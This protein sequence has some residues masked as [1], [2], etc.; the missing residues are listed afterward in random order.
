MSKS[1]KL[2]QSRKKVNAP[3]TLRAIAR[4][5]T[6]QIRPLAEDELNWFRFQ[7]D[8]GK[9]IKFAGLAINSKGKRYSHQRRIRKGVLPQAEYLLTS[10]LKAIRQCT[11]FG[12][13]FALINS[14]LNSVDGIGELYIYDT[15]LRIGANLNLL[16][17]KIYLHTGTREGA[18]ALGFGGKLAYIEVSDLPNGL[19]ELEPHEIEDVLCIFKDNLKQ[20]KFDLPNQEIRRRSWCD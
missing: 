7:P 14:L 15:A 11:S 8:L 6:E 20:M 9:T 3:T 17:E 12:E 19:Q 13:L 1:R 2:V 16:P 4:A 5:Y 18:R 10:N